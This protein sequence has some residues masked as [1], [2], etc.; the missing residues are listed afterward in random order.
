MS[1]IA[2]GGYLPEILSRRTNQIP[3]YAIEVPELVD[4]VAY[5]QYY[6]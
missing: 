3:V 1:V 5:S 4:I 2:K 6:S